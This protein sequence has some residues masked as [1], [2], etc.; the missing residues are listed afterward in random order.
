MITVAFASGAPSL[1]SVRCPRPRPRRLRPRPRRSSL[2]SVA[3]LLSAVDG[4]SLDLALTAS[5]SVR[6]TSGR[7]VRPLRLRPR[8][9]WRGFASRAPSEFEAAS[10]VVPAGRS[11]RSL[12]SPR[13]P[14]L[15][16]PRSPPLRLPSRP[17]ALRPRGAGAAGLTSGSLEENSFLM[18]PKRP[19]ELDCVSA[20]AVRAGRGWVTGAGWLGVMPFTA[21]SGRAFTSPS[22]RLTTVSASSSRAASSAM[23]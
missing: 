23:T 9:S 15:R 2:P 18:K 10:G 16:P 14:R 7:S 6:A 8:P 3:E 12:R 4:A 22:L 17:W 19:P 13:R 20:L 1:R 5:A 21:A 11:P